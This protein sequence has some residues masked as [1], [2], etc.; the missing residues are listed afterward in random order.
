MYDIWG[1]HGGE[2]SNAIWTYWK[3]QTFQRNILSPEDGGSVFLSSVGIYLQVHMEFAWELPVY[4]VLCF[5]AM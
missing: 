3:I 4:D 5:N 2:D 1:S